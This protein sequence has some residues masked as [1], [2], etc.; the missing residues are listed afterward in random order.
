M[1]W[2]VAD[3]AL[4]SSS[5]DELSSSLSEEKP[6]NDGYG[7]VEGLSVEG[8]NRRGERFAAGLVGSLALDRPAFPCLISPREQVA[9]SPLDTGVGSL[10]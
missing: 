6:L 10:S 4:T 7:S 3:V 8:T 2:R 9:T 5:P 1:A